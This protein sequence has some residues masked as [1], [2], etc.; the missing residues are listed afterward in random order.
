MFAGLTKWLATKMGPKRSERFFQFT[1]DLDFMFSKYLVGRMLE[2]LVV[3]ILCF[4]MML[5]L[6]LPYGMLMSTL[7]GITN[8]IPYVGPV[9]G[10]IPI[11][12]LALF[13]NPAT[14]LIAAILLTLI[15]GFDAWVLSPKVLGDSMGL[16]PFWIVFA[17]VIGGA[18]FG[19]V[20]LL[21]STPVMG[22]LM[23]MVERSVERINALDEKVNDPM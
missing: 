17:L 5:A 22:V 1:H 4:I 16:N 18:L 3:G 10:L 6:D 13:R 21:L 23:R 2:S 12:L 14:A 15:Q 7:Y 9:I 8:M 19:V 20:G 11:V